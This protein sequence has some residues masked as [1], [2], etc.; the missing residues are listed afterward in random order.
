MN[1]ELADVIGKDKYYTQTATAKLKIKSQDGN[2]DIEGQ[3]YTYRIDKAA[4]AT[5]IGKYG[6]TTTYEKDGKSYT[7]TFIGSQ[8]EVLVLLKNL[9]EK[10]TDS[11]AATN[12]ATKS[13]SDAT[14]LAKNNNKLVDVTAADK[15]WKAAGGNTVSQGSTSINRWEALGEETNQ[16]AKP[17]L[18][19]NNLTDS[20]DKKKVLENLDANIELTFNESVQNPD[21]VEL[22]DT[23]GTE[24]KS[25]DTKV[26][27]TVTLEN[28]STTPNVE[29]TKVI[30]NPD[31][32]LTAGGKY[33]VRNSGGTK[34]EDLAVNPNAVSDPVINFSTASTSVTGA[35]TV[36]NTNLGTIDATAADASV[37]ITFDKNIAVVDGSGN[38]TVNNGSAD[39]TLGS[40][41]YEIDGTKLKIKKE[42]LTALGITDNSTTDRTLTVKEG[43]IADVTD[44]NQKNVA[45]DLTFKTEVASDT[46]PNPV[47]KDPVD[48]EFS[49]NAP[50]IL[51]FENPIKL[52]SGRTLDDSTVTIVE[53]N[54]DN[55]DGNTVTGMGYTAN[56]NQLTITP[57]T[58]FTAQKKYKIIISTDTLYKDNGTEL[59]GGQVSYIFTAVEPDK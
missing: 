3:A 51:N 30:I 58:P 35:P 40:D 13:Y 29:N 23:K 16:N 41:K 12:V 54:D 8:G 15:E 5:Q 39:V 45:T 18:S 6:L 55:T 24:N 47:I 10:E 22:W 20:S 46:S 34:L 33:E 50:I 37:D 56:G 59:Y 48:K 28:D 49:N 26:A 2:E 27:A 14:P 43:Q 42:G 21:G 1:R 32:P 38:I 53:L 25:D 52:A 31:D 44:A 7:D 4:D 57:T 17:E 19:A 36:S 9:K 11:S